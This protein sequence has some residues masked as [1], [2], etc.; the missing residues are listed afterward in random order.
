MTLQTS[1]QAPAQSL[2][3]TAPAA[4]RSELTS[5]DPLGLAYIAQQVGLLLLPTLTT[6]SNR[7]QA[8]AMVLYG[9]ALA[10]RA[11]NEHGHPNTDEER[12]RLFERWERFWALST[13]EHRG[14][15]LPRGDWDSMRG[16]LGAHAAWKPGEK[17][18]P[19]DFP[20]ISR[21]QELGN[22]GAYLAPLRRSGLVRDGDVRPTPAAMEIIEAFWREPDGSARHRR[23]EEYALTAL[24]PNRKTIERT[25]GKLS[26]ARLGER[27]RLSVLTRMPRVA[28]Q[29]RLHEA[30]F[31]NARDETTQAMAEIV[32]V[33][34]QADVFE[35]E[36]VIDGALGGRF[37]A[38]SPRLRDVLLTAQAFGRYMGHLLRAF[39]RAFS[40]VERAGL[41]VDRAEAAQTAFGAASQAELTRAASVL[42]D[43]PLVSAIRHLPMHGAAC[44]RLADEMRTA[45]APAALDLMLAY[46]GLVQRDRR[47]GVGW[48]R[49]EDDKLTLL[50]TS[51]RAQPDE[52]FFPAYKLP[53]LRTLLVDTGRLPFD[54]GTAVPELSV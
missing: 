33:A 14:Q 35:T 47:R 49:Q 34:T 23:Y 44:L 37:G 6:R 30:L 10:D 19:V 48:I 38:L 40:K 43:A 21:Q 29:K 31:E 5:E 32:R 9:L 20:L 15:A 1:L 28:Q 22:L 39:D 41:I 11:V 18:L 25:S 7:A 4:D 2:F 27:S 13:L 52:L 16:I 17:P 24:E 26:M 3:W 36:E 46:H 45:S 54:D 8:Y 42:L 51:Y 50:V 53:A 12:R